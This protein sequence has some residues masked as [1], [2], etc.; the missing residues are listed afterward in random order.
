MKKQYTWQEYR[1]IDL[2]LMAVILAVCEYLLVASARFWFPEQLYTVSLAGAMAAIVFMRWGA[3]GAIHAFEAGF[4]F[5]LFSG[6]TG[7][8]FVIYCI[9]N[10]FSLPAALLLDRIGKEKVRGSAI[11]SVLFALLVL[12]W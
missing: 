8:Q 3:W 11:L 5:C 2:S 7:V 9:G 12:V 4:V 6:G 1:A 10:L